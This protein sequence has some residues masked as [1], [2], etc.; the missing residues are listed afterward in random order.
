VLKIDYQLNIL[1]L[2]SIIVI[3]LVFQVHFSDKSA[4]YILRQKILR[5][6]NGSLS[7]L[8]YIPQCNHLGRYNPDQ[9]FRNAS[10]VCVESES[11]S[12]LSKI[13]PYGDPLLNCHKLAADFRCKLST[14]ICFYHIAKKETLTLQNKN[15][16]L[17]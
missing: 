4:C 15:L 14:K 8:D 2:Q 12:H 7:S 16:L 10:I 3:H 5:E 17:C 6:K 1:D 13:I 9:V 11:G